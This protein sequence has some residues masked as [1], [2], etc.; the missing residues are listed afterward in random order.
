MLNVY[1]FLLFVLIAEVSHCWLGYSVIPNMSSFVEGVSNL[2][3]KQA[4]RLSR[5]VVF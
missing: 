2:D 4:S 3:S 1:V 5:F